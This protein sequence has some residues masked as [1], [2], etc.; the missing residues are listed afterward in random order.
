MK[1][2]QEEYFEQQ[3]R[4][5]DANGEESYTIRGDD[6]K[7][8]NIIFQ[9]N[10]GEDKKMADDEINDEALPDFPEDGKVSMPQEKEEVDLNNID[11]EAIARAREEL[12]QKQRRPYEARKRGVEEVR[13]IMEDIDSRN[14][15]PG[16]HRGNTAMAKMQSRME[17]KYSDKMQAK[18]EELVEKANSGLG[19][20]LK[21][22]I[23][24]KP[25][26][27]SRKKV[28][29]EVLKDVYTHTARDKGIIDVRL[30]AYKNEFNELKEEY[31]TLQKAYVKAVD[32]FNK[33][34]TML[35]TLEEDLT[36]AIQQRDTLIGEQEGENFNDLAYSA[37]QT[38]DELTEQLQDLTDDQ[39]F[40]RDAVQSSYLEL[41][42][43]ERELE[44]ADVDYKTAK[45]DALM[46]KTTAK[47]LDRLH[48][49]KNKQAGKLKEAQEQLIEDEHRKDAAVYI[50]EANRA[51]DDLT[52]D[53]AKRLAQDKLYNGVPRPD[54]K[55]KATREILT[56]RNEKILKYAVAKRYNISPV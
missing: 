28:L 31:N 43:V 30:E 47:Q 36:K 10:V 53:R 48:K 26:K 42:I 32:E 20:K 25:K 4:N 14:K 17:E 13:A 51:V 18:E 9:Q 55:V 37:Q 45:D 46:Q 7:I 34:D 12:T 22:L 56:Q 16:E 52:Y 2:E 24:I 35:T 27:P 39:E 6:G 1:E 29:D 15:M 11:R 40:L 38:V 54:P 41:S 5:A 23:G 3:K 19:A 50:E 8:Q 44:R 21:G 49:K 33:G